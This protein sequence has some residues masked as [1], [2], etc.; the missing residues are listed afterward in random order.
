MDLQGIFVL[1]VLCQCYSFDIELP[2]FCEFKKINKLEPESKPL[3]GVYASC[4]K[5]YKEY[6][7][8]RFFFCFLFFFFQI[9]DIKILGNLSPKK[10]KISLIY[11]SLEEKKNSQF[12]RRW[13]MSVSTL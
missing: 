10:C 4:W 5:F 7:K 6:E 13:S 1:Q 12:E 2:F 3:K 9:F 8:G 11:T